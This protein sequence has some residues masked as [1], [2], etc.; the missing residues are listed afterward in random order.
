MPVHDWSR[1]FPGAFHDFHQAWTAEIRKALNGGLLP[2]GYYAA[3]E[4][5]VSGPEPD[6]V[7]L[8]SCEPDWDSYDSSPNRRGNV[9]VAEKRP[10]TVRYSFKVDQDNYAAKAN[11]VAIK[12]A[13]DHKTVAIIEVVSPGN[14]HS[15]RAFK[16]FT[17][18]LNCVQA[19]WLGTNE[20]VATG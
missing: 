7:A 13:S 2:K 15:R 20:S 9:M 19:Y 17:D 12:H 5:I 6:V 3:I 4:Q 18:K 14:K 10:P 1:I 8:E 16:E 11:L